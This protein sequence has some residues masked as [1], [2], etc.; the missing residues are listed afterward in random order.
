MKNLYLTIFSILALCAGCNSDDNG[1]DNKPQDE[2]Q[3]T[4]YDE[5]KEAIA[6]IDYKDEATIYTFEGEPVA[7]IEPKEQVYSFNGKL[8]GW[9]S[10]GV[11]YDNKTHHAVGAK[12]GIAKGG[13]NTVVTH[14]E[15]IKG[16]K[17]I[18]PI[19]PVKGNDFTSPV[20]IDSWSETTLTDFFDT[21][22]K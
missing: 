8:L 13:I 6:Y 7:Y 15:K 10:G 1:D 14:P 22:K 21:G 4:L 11:L 18:K 16:V 12:H 3:I 2:L 9:Y 19:K 20:L 17:Q 5:N